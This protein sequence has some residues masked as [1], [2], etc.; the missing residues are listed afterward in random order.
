ML[1]NGDVHCWDLTL[2]GEVFKLPEFYDAKL[3]RK[4]KNLISIRNNVAH[5]G[6]L[7]VLEPDFQKY[8]LEIS[9][10][11]TIFNYPKEEIE[12]IK[13]ED[14]FKEEKAK[15]PLNSEISEAIKLKNLGNKAFEKKEYLDAVNFYTKAIA[16]GGVSDTDLSILYRNRATAYYF[17]YLSSKDETDILQSIMDAKQSVHLNPLSFKAYLKLANSYEKLEKFDK[18]IVNLEKALKLQP[19]NKEIID[20]LAKIKWEQGS[21]ERMEHLEQD[22]SRN[23]LRS[24]K[25]K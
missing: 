14:I 13:I 12:R 1:E 23:H 9:D 25:M 2:L 15:N 21:R 22:Y 24:P 10:F 16:T 4:L 8:F 6:D 19:G 11:L 3:D 18:A 7:K 5:N 17:I 20:D